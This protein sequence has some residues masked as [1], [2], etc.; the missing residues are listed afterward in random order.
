MDGLKLYFYI[1][2]LPQLYIN[3]Y[4]LT[5]QDLLI[6]FYLSFSSCVGDRRT[7]GDSTRGS[8]VGLS[9]ITEHGWD[10]ELPHAYNA[11]T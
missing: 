8:G 5:G 3:I 9:G 4:Y 1:F 11:R 2:P 6:T 7:T 10:N